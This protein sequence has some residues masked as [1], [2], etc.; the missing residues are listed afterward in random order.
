MTQPVLRSLLFASIAPLIVVQPVIAQSAVYVSG[1]GFAEI[2][3]FDSV[4]YDPRILASDDGFSS[5]ATGAGG[6]VRI[7]TFLHPRWSLEL[8]VDAGSKTRKAIPNPYVSILGGPASLRIPELAAST[9]FLTVSTVI[10]FHPPKIRRVSLGYFGGLSIVRGTYESDLPDFRILTA[11]SL[12]FSS[13][14]NIGTVV[15][16]VVPPPNFGF[17]SVKRVDHSFGAIVGFEA[18]IDLTGHIAAVPGGRAIMF[19]N[20]GQSVLLVRPEIGVRW[21]F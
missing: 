9:R 8:A 21:S 4:S 10:G 13:S 20:I 14:S 6:G 7:G 11:S 12:T 15:P 16:V 19:S 5:D 3:R 17:R 18:A 2:K 1:V